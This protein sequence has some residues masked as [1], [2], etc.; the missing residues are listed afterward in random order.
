M[1]LWLELRFSDTQTLPSRGW[2]W[3]CHSNVHFSHICTYTHSKAHTRT[4]KHTQFS[5][6]TNLRHLR[7]WSSS[8][9]ELLLCIYWFLP[10]I[11]LLVPCSVNAPSV[12]SLESGFY[13]FQLPGNLHSPTPGSVFHLC[14]L[15]SRELCLL[16]P[17]PGLL[18]PDGSR[19]STL[20]CPQPFLVCG[21]TGLHSCGWQGSW[22][23]AWKKSKF[24]K[25]VQSR[26]EMGL[27]WGAM[28]TWREF[29]FS[30]LSRL[31]HILFL[32]HPTFP[33]LHTIP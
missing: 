8:L 7:F 12:Y 26:R 23:Q 29:I 31:G 15:S 25:S 27:A 22:E 17:S 14:L 18:F 33:G 1:T 24:M 11:W 5:F 6:L 21:W 9:L 3:S 4:H 13:P 28:I 30:I 32:W 2:G 16:I 19:T 10:H 20:P